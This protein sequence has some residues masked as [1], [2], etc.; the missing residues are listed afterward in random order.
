MLYRAVVS[1]MYGAKGF[2]LICADVVKHIPKQNVQTQTFLIGRIAK[3]W[4][5]S[6]ENISREIE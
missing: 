4:Y 5:S 3:S 1:A 2:F 6:M